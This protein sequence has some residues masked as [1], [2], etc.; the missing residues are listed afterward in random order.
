MLGAILSCCLAFPRVWLENVLLMKR[1]QTF[2]ALDLFLAAALF[3]I[4]LLK[5]TKRDSLGRN[6]HVQIQGLKAA[7]KLL[8]TCIERSFTCLWN[9]S[10]LYG[11]LDP[12]FVL[13]QF[14]L[15]SFKF[16][17][18]R[19]TGLHVYFGCIIFCITFLVEASSGWRMLVF[20]VGSF[21]MNRV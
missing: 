14:Y 9:F 2:F 19:S 6:F 11:I 7:R 8:L 17:S 21:I 13:L 1:L 16:N 12:L 4:L 3:N 10:L 15:P 5:C 18:L 20:I